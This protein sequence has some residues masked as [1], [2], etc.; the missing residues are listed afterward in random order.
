[1]QTYQA[2]ERFLAA[3]RSKGLATATISKYEAL[4]VSFARSST[5]LP[6][7]PEPIECYLASI[8]NPES[9]QTYFRTL[10]TFFR[11]LHVRGY[12]E[13][14]PMG[15]IEAPR[16]P[17]RVA[18]ALTEDWLASLLIHPTHSPKI[19][20]FLWLIT[21]TGLRL[22]EALSA[23][24]ARHYRNG[25]VVVSGKTGERE[26]PIS[27]RVAR[28]V[29]PQLPWRWGSAP[30]A[31]LA[32]RRAFNRAGIPGPGASAQALRHT[33]VRLWSGDESV[34]VGIM[35]WTTNRMLTR[36]RPYDIH[37]AKSQHLENSPLLRLDLD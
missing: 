36:Y 23:G 4:L 7:T 1:M 19:R 21:D 25:C 13:T 5:D 16:V 10:T 27:D 22:G 15:P 6:D 31:G 18:R 26:V 17:R 37:R 12:I 35:G 11:W 32:V 3:K 33:F 29:V 28:M 24:S 34:L 8:V 20:A 14:I 9:R 2:I 30:S